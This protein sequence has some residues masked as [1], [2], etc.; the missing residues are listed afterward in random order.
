VDLGTNSLR[1]SARQWSRTTGGK[2]FD[3]LSEQWNQLFHC[4]ISLRSRDGRE[5]V[6]TNQKI[7][8]KVFYGVEDTLRRVPTALTISQQYHKLMFHNDIAIDHAAVRVLANDAPA[9]DVYVML[10]RDL[11]ALEEP[12][13][14]DWNTVCRNY[15]PRWPAINCAKP[16]FLRNLAKALAVYP[17]ARIDVKRDGIELHPSP[18]PTECPLP[19]Q[20]VVDRLTKLPAMNLTNAI[21]QT[22][23]KTQSRRND[24]KYCRV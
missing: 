23:S 10:A 7:A 3:A 15:G 17:C 14:R 12:L 1:E 19:D 5:A 8:E 6:P 11:P 22:A 21:R 16:A 9:L 20:T 18:R 2:T 13:F 24:D 4:T